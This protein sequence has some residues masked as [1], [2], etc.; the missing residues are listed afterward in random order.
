MAK[1]SLLLL[2]ELLI[3][4]TPSLSCPEYQKQALLNFKASLINS[5]TTTSSSEG[6]R[7]LLF[8]SWNSSSDC[9]N[10]ERVNCSSSLGSRTVIALYLN[11]LVDQLPREHTVLTS[12]ILT[13]LFHIG[14]LTHLNMSKN[15]IQGQLPSDGFANLTELIS[16][17]LGSNDFFGSIPSQLFQL[18][19]LQYLDMSSNNF[20]DIP[21]EIGNMTE[22]RHLEFLD[23]SKNHLEGMFPQWLAEM[24]VAFIILSDN[25]LT[26]SLPPF[27]FNSINLNVLS[28]SRNNFY[29]QLPSNIGNATSLMSL[30]LND[31]NF[32][33]KIPDSIT[34]LRFTILDLS[35]NK[36]SGNSLPD[37]SSNMLPQVIDLS[38][39]ELSGE[40]STNFSILTR[41]LSLGKNKFSGIMSTNLNTMRILECLDIHDNKITGELP[42]FIC[43]I[44]TLRILNLR[45]NSFQ[46]SI[47]DCISNLTSLQILDL[48]SN[49]LVGKIPAKF[50]NFTGMIR[51]SNEPISDVPATFTPSFSFKAKINDLI[52]NWKKSTQGLSWK[53]LM[54]YSL[55]DLSMN[56]LSGEIPTTL[57]SLKALKVFNVSHN[58]LYGRIPASLGDLLNVESLDLS[59]NNLSS[60][61]PK[62]LEKLQQLT[63]LDVSNNKLAGRIPRGSQM[64][65]MNDPNFFANNSGLCGMQIRVL[66]PEDFPPTKVPPKPPKVENKERWFSWEGVGIGYAIS[67]IIT[68]GVLYLAKYFVPATPP[69]Y[70]RQQRRRRI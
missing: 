62:S 17:D 31:N 54:I 70:R 47:H 15:K 64:D 43:Q 6:Q 67:F 20:H 18:R 69:N 56:Q 40:I 68:V 50:G 41:V 7:V 37:F 39:N 9:C 16:L 55:L 48:S 4:F 53:N 36:F 28:L 14:S 29:G 35:N 27:L 23:L 57:G 2:L 8:E 3:F 42:D 63:I 44:S 51:T 12:N 60:S 32:S 45:N 58:N 22:L 66:C 21:K 52:I 26:S 33:G 24:E 59:Y 1:L 65:T 49:H 11:D 34:N 19:Y 13:P 61:I 5:T 30:V 25:N 10:W 38:S 46:G